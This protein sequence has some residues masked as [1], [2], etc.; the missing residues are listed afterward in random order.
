[1][2]NLTEEN[3]AFGVDGIDN[4][5]PSLNMVFSPYARGLRIAL[6][7]VRDASGFSNEKASVGS[8]LGVVEDGMGLWDV[9]VRPLSGKRCQNNSASKI[10]QQLKSMEIGRKKR[11]RDTYGTD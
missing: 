9:V 11:D 8:S 3:T 10:N 1:M 7:R 5:F 2:P 4:G 6:S